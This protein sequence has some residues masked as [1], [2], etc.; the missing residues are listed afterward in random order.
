MQL[1]E[2]FF[3]KTRYQIINF[4]NRANLQRIISNVISM[5]ESLYSSVVG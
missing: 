3:I 4:N 1:I 5:R 2:F